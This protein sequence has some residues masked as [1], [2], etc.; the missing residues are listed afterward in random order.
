L[1]T[2]PQPRE[3]RTHTPSQDQAV[4][5]RNSRISSSHPGALK[6]LIPRSSISI[7]DGSDALGQFAGNTPPPKQLQLKASCYFNK[8]VDDR[9]RVVLDFR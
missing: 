2:K 8:A 6:R 5:H 1:L 9:L 4:R 7:A 3:H